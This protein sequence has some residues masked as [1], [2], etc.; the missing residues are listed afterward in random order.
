MA[1]IGMGALINKNTF[2]GALIGK[3]ALNRIITVL[4]NRGRAYGLPGTRPDALPLSHRKLV[5]AK[6]TKGLF[7]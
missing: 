6:D 4:P 1:L 3:R 2:E 7:T 5:R